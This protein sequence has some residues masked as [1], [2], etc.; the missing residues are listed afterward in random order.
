MCTI[1]IPYLLAVKGLIRYPVFTI[2]TCDNELF[3]I[4]GT[5]LAFDNK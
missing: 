5:I 4:Q 3:L 2:L 1:G